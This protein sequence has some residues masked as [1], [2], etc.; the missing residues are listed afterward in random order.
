MAA[1]PEVVLVRSE[2]TSPKTA[3]AS[4]V[5]LAS[6]DLRVLA[7]LLAAC[8]A[9]S[10]TVTSDY[11][12]R[13]ARIARYPFSMAFRELRRIGFLELAVQDPFGDTLDTYRPSSSAFDWARLH[14]HEM[15]PPAEERSD[16]DD[17]SF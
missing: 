7:A 1:L 2:G 5:V 8:P 6:H 4:D 11:L 10:D 13:R 9:D 14:P 15:E 17:V 3:S 16:E 12:A